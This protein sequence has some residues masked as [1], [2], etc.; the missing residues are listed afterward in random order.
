MNQEQRQRKTETAREWRAR[1]PYKSATASAKYRDAHPER[2]TDIRAKAQAKPEAKAKTS[3]RCAAWRLNN[4]EKVSQLRAEWKK[5]NAAHVNAYTAHRVALKI[6]A[7]PSWSE[8]EIIEL[9]YAEAKH[10]GLTVDHV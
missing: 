2:W 5:K 1:N 3:A 9:I 10:R 8:P 6:Q 7:S 4:P